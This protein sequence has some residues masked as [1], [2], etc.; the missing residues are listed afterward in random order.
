DMP[1][2]LLLARKPAQVGTVFAEHYLHSFH[3]NR[4]DSCQVDTTEPV[5]SLTQGLFP[6]F[7]NRLG[8]LRIFQLCWLLSMALRP[9][10][11]RQFP[12]YLPLIIGDLDDIKEAKRLMDASQYVATAATETA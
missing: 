12:Q 5:Q 10:H 11:L 1:D 2:A 7:L 4:I 9:L 3:A 6:S 8:L